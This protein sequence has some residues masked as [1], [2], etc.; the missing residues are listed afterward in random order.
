MTHLE[1]G[2]RRVPARLLDKTSRRRVLEA[3]ALGAVVSACSR[4]T[5]DTTSALVAP[6]DSTAPPTSL[7]GAT[8]TAA[9]GPDLVRVELPTRSPGSQA[10]PALA[11]PDGVT[12]PQVRAVPN[13]ALPTPAASNPAAPTTTVVGPPTTA[14]V[15][16]VADPGAGTTAVTAPAPVVTS[17][18]APSTTFGAP[19]AL[20][21][22]AGVI[23]VANRLTFGLTPALQRQIESQGTAG[24]IEDQL[25]KNSPDPA[26]E[27]RLGSFQLLG[28]SPKATYDRLR[29]VG[30]GRLRKELTHLSVLRST[31]SDHQLFEMMGQLWMD[32]FN[33]HLL[34]E[35]RTQH[36]HIDYLENVI[37]PNAMGTFRDLLL[38]TAE[39]PAMLT[40][41]NNDESNANSDKGVNENYGRELLELHTLGIDEAGNQAYSEADVRAA[42]LAMS[43]WSMESSRNDA[44]Y[45]EFRF[46]DDYHHAG[47]ISI[48]DGAWTSEGTSGKT[49]GESLLEFLA[50]HPSTARHLAYKLCVRFVA[51]VPPPGL[52]ASTAQVFL[53]ND[54]AL[55]PTLLHL[56]TS[57]EFAAAEGQKLRRPFE[58]MV[59]TIRALNATVPGDPDGD[60]AKRLRNRLTQQ[61]HEPWAWD[62]PNGYPDDANHWLSADGMVNRW[63][64][65]SRLALDREDVEPDYAAIRPTAATTGEL[66]TALGHQFGLGELPGT[67]RSAVAEAARLAESDPATDVD[68]ERLGTIA[69]LLFTHPLFQTR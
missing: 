64:L 29:D 66:I 63:N 53:D 1:T 14:A 46:R 36:L 42:S 33:I 16:V 17:P 12:N 48:L 49:T 24:F 56:F 13:P 9:T 10:P 50:S 7:A 28:R 39:S 20:A 59:A 51:D 2:T 27:G 38:A 47:P 45:S 62:Q 30:G 19:Q 22:N 15:P 67:I 3:L 41:L 6:T 65:G 23:H 32:H 61:D 25:A 26:V 55:V 35:G 4:S 31:N 68:D 40:Y 43:G 18:P 60:A 11:K 21:S 44:D 57:A 34:G 37:R 5:D 54:T 8:E 52:V 69:G 58:A